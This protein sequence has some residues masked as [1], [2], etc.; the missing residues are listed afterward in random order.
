[1]DQT[2]R[3][4]RGCDAAAPAHSAAR[5]AALAARRIVLVNYTVQNVEDAVAVRED[6]AAQPAGVVVIDAAVVERHSI[7]GAVDENAAPARD[8]RH[9]ATGQRQTLHEDVVRLCNVQ[10]VAAGARLP[11]HR[12]VAPGA[13]DDHGVVRE[14][15]RFRVELVDTLGDGNPD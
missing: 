12:A 14:V 4:A 2:Q 6:A 8:C 13:T 5:H 3:R 7:A 9:P 10:D 15:Q 1:M 11:D